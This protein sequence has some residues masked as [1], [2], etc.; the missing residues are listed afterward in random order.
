LCADEKDELLYVSKYVIE[1][2]DVQSALARIE[3]VITAYNRLG[4]ADEEKWKKKTGKLCEYCDYYKAKI[5]DG[6]SC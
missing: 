5:C 3:N 4:T 1:K 2:D 6:K